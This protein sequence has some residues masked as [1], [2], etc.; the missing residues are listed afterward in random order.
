MS[1]RCLCNYRCSL[2]C[3]SAS[4]G[5]GSLQNRSQST[6]GHVVCGQNAPQASFSAH[7]YIILG[8]WIHPALHNWLPFKPFANVKFANLLCLFLC[9]VEAPAKMSVMQLAQNMCFPKCIPHQNTGPTTHSKYT[10]IRS[11]KATCSLAVATTALFGRFQAA[12][13]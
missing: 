8:S 2:P 7:G 1:S 12:S 10:A 5:A 11:D 3:F 4:A 13:N 6:S 9:S